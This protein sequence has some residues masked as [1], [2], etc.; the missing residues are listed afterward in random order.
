MSFLKVTSFCFDLSLKK[1]NQNNEQKKRGP[2][3][4][5]RLSLKNC[6]SRSAIRL[7][8]STVLIVCAHFGRVNR[9]S[10]GSPFLQ[11][12]TA[13]TRAHTRAWYVQH[14]RVDTEQQAQSKA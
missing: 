10:T 5:L 1:I 14:T 2:L 8:S 6:A 7:V 4:P 12:N 11:A 9:S 13:Y 3:E